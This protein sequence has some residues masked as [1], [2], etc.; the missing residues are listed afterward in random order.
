MP[1]RPP[2]SDD[3]SERLAALAASVE[4]ELDGAG[5][6]IGIEARRLASMRLAGWSRCGWA[7]SRNVWPMRE[8]LITLRTFRLAVGARTMSFLSVELPAAGL[9]R[10]LLLDVAEANYDATAALALGAAEFNFG[11][12]FDAT[13]LYLDPVG[14]IA[15]G[16]LLDEAAEAAQI[17]A[18]RARISMLAKGRPERL[19]APVIVATLPVQ[20]DAVVGSADLVVVGSDLRLV[21]AV[22]DSIRDG[23]AQGAW[24][25]WDVAGLARDIGSHVWF[26]PIR[27]HQARRPSPSNSRRLSPTIFA[28]CSPSWLANPGALWF[29]TST[30]RFGVAC[31]PTMG[32]KALPR[33]SSWR[34]RLFVQHTI[35]GCVKRGVCLP[36]ARRIMK[37]L[38]AALLSCT[39]TWRYGWNTSPFSKPTG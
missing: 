38:L 35:R 10:G 15:P 14:L 11:H 31:S 3:W 29:S 32:S 28:A 4:G 23:A 9:A 19:K 33:P 17:Y 6:D 26:D 20:P 7:N 8:W 34:A 30:T 22:N 13:L 37:T 1:W 25:L 2:L 16:T 24:L 36:Y 5:A 12:G 21:A 18:A 39:R 27:W